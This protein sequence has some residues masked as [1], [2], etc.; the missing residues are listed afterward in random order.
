M[1]RYLPAIAFVGVLV[2]WSGAIVMLAAS[3][4]G[5]AVV[6]WLLA[7]SSMLY[8]IIGQLLPLMIFRGHDG[9]R[10]AAE[11]ARAVS[12]SGAPVAWLSVAPMLTRGPLATATLYPTGICMNEPFLAPYAVLLQDIT[13]IEQKVR[14]RIR[15]IRIIHASP[16][17]QSPLVLTAWPWPS[18]GDFQQ[19]A[20]ELARRMARPMGD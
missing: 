6:M 2:G 1:K 13:D 15:E 9:R 19:F 11:A 18:G 8:L 4:M 3:R 7:L 16:D 20:E 17:V 12:S 14:G 5:G 10:R